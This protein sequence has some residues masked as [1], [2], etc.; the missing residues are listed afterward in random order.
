MTHLGLH[1]GWD[2]RLLNYNNR[3]VVDST[4]SVSIPISI[5]ECGNR[6]NML[7]QLDIFQIPN[8]GLF[9]HQLAE[10]KPLS[11]APKLWP[12]LRILRILRCPAGDKFHPSEDNNT[13]LSSRQDRDINELLITIPQALGQMPC[14]EELLME[15]RNPEVESDLSDDIDLADDAVLPNDTN[16]I[17]DLA[18][19]RFPRL[20]PNAPH[21]YRHHPS[22][23]VLYIRTDI[24][25]EQTVRKQWQSSVSAEWSRTLFGYQCTLEPRVNLD[26]REVKFWQDVDHELDATEVDLFPEEAQSIYFNSV[27]TDSS[28]FDLDPED[29]A[30]CSWAYAISRRFRQE[31]ITR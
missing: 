3:Q 13:L 23:A 18:L 1:A 21:I 8:F 20:Y 30:E 19:L 9:F 27:D 15:V 25:T 31:Q 2:L 12:N 24:S 28:G 5:A 4:R 26:S 29:M 6:L 17:L 10:K 11:G 22:A 7:T 16:Q 14:L